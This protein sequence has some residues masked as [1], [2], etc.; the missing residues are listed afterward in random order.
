[1]SHFAAVMDASSVAPTTL[2]K[3]KVSNRVFDKMINSVVEGSVPRGTKAT[4]AWPEGIK[5][6]YVCSSRGELRALVEKDLRAVYE[7]TG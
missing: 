7:V 3:K 1:M 5:K 2:G 4:L 6:E